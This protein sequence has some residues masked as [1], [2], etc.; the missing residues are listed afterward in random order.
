MQLLMAVVKYLSAKHPSKKLWH[1]LQSWGFLIRKTL[2]K[3][4]DVI[5]HFAK[6]TERNYIK[7]L[8]TLVTSDI[9]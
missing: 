2:K 5:W 8:F 3:C 6:G 4:M 7:D 9:I 1:V